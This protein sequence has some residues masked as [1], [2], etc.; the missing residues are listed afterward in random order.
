MGAAA[1]R[2]ALAASGLAVSDLDAIICANSCPEQLIPCNGALVQ[3]ELGAGTSGIPAFDINSTCL[4]F[5]VAFD[6]AST[7]L[8]AGHY[9]RVLLVASEVASVGLDWDDP[10]SCLFGDAAAAV[11]LARTPAGMTSRV[12]RSRIETHGEGADSCRIRAG[13]TH[14]FGTNYTKERRHEFLFAMDG[15]G[16]YR[17][18]RRKL[19]P[20]VAALF[21]GSG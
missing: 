7:L 15:P 4:S 6:L 2:Q 14:V 18:A 1:A 17:M 3:R 9:R 16:L 13:G 21:D 8:E 11:V 5:L 19:P 12:L 20:M 10:E